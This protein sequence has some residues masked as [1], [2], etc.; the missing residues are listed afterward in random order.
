MI[1]GGFGPK[2]KKISCYSLISTRK[3][4]TLEGSPKHSIVVVY[5]HLMFPLQN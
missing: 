1:N 3:H 4:V 2:I 5:I